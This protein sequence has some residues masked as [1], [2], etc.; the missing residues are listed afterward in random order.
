MKNFRAA[1]EFL[2]IPKIEIRRASFA[3]PDK[4]FRRR[5]NFR[6]ERVAN[7]RIYAKRNKKFA[8]SKIRVSLARNYKL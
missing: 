7:S 6:H 4:K 1:V 5:G 3:N 8:N 2:Q